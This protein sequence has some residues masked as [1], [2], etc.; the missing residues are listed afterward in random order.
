M[1]NGIVN[2]F[3]NLP[4][5][6]YNYFNMRRKHVHFGKNLSVYGKLFIP[7]S[8]EGIL[9]GDDVSIN[10]GY[11]YNSVAGG[12]GCFFNVR[13]GAKLIIG[14]NVG[15][16]HAAITCWDNIIIEDSVLIGSN[17]MIC[18]TDFHPLDREER[19]NRDSYDNPTIKIAP[20]TIKKGAFI[21]ARSVIL[22]GVT[23]GEYSIVGAGSVV[24]SNVPYGEVWAGNP[25]RFIKKI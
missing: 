3:R 15:I 12:I 9:I 17:C 11:R 5:A 4:S 13:N 8:G 20:V 19:I 24:V 2:F 25:A 23:I 6:I 1:L 7:E 21:G 10:C 22:K 16:S 14:N 18:D